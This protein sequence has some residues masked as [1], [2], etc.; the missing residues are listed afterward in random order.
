MATFRFSLPQP[1]SV[2][3]LQGL[4]SYLFAFGPTE[5]SSEFLR[6]RQ[7]ADNLLL[8]RGQGM[9]WTVGLGA[10]CTAGQINAVTLRV[11]GVTQLSVTGLTLDAQ[12]AFTIAAVDELEFL[13]HLFMGSDRIFLTTQD[14][15]IASFGGNDRVLA[16]GGNDTVYG[17]KGNDSL[18]G[19]GGDDVLEGSD[20]N[21]FLYGGPGSTGTDNNLY[22]GDG[23]DFLTG[24]GGLEYSNGG[25]GRDTLVGGVWFDTLTGGAGA[26][27]FVFRST[28]TPATNPFITDFQPGVDEILLDND[29]FAALGVP[30]NLTHGQFREGVSATDDSDRI[31]Y[32]QSTGRIW[33]D[34]DG[35]GSA[36]KKLILIL[37]STPDI[38]FDDFRIIN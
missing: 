19:G 38:A 28:S 29:R 20:G 5:V 25:N 14:D 31:I 23:N 32:D 33:Y 12:T 1:S 34:A 35:S 15:N 18:F 37:T 36:A 30:G 13:Q 22:G 16:Y 26:D 11:G 10:I 8:I 17:G 9:V 24:G 2:T 6:E 7:D 3:T 4:A 27:D 21:D